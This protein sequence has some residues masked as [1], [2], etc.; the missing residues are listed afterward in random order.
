MFG[1]SVCC[2][3]PLIVRVLC[4]WRLLPPRVKG[5][6]LNRQETQSSNI[7]FCICAFVSGSHEG[8]WLTIPL[9]VRSSRFATHVVPT[10]TSTKPRHA[11]EYNSCSCRRAQLELILWNQI[12]RT[13]LEHV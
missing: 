6:V 11:I 5:C 8:T 10:P 2:T 4:P 9:G 3:P 13:K 1:V 12:L 7:R